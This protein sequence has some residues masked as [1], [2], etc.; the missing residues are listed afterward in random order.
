MPSDP[1]GTARSR[2]L[3]LPAACCILALAACSGQARRNSPPPEHTPGTATHV[4]GIGRRVTLPAQPRRIVSLAPSVT[5]VLFL[6]DLGDRVIGLTTHCDWPEAAAAKPRIGTLLSPDYERIIA[7]GPDLIIA[8]TAGNDRSAVLKLHDL[9]L[10]LFVTAPRSVDAIFETVRAISRIT[11][12]P[13]RGD[14][15]TAD[16]GRRLERIRAAL[17]GLPA[18]RAFFITWFDPLLAPGRRTFENDVLRRAHVISISAGSEEFYPRYSLEQVL[19][20]DPE[21]ILTVGHP[22]HPLPDL[23][24]LPGWERLAAVRSGRVYVLSDVLQHPSP[25]FI[26]GVEELA[27][28]LFPERFP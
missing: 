8:S 10:P 6:L 9:G 3:L 7:A 24:H 1:S 22:G 2:I 11:G 16:M 27:R 12:C 4:D 13:E 25:R 26:D 20:Q 28:T 5:E 15:L 21:V 14:E 18:R 19:A 23:R 17:D